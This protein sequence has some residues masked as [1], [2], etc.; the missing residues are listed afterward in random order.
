LALR[1][2]AGTRLVGNDTRCGLQ[3]RVNDP[4]GFFHVILP[5]KKG[6]VSRHRVSEHPFVGLHLFGTRAVS[7][8]YFQG[9]VP[10]FIVRGYVVHA[11]GKRD[12]RTDSQPAMIRLQIKALIHGWWLTQSDHDLRAGHGQ[13]LPGPEVEG[14]AAPAPGIDLQLERRKGL[15]PGVG[16]NA[17]LVAIATELPTD[18]V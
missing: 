11:D 1:W 8:R 9:I 18:K 4:P 3:H 7:P 17:W 16:L 10:C 12:V 15:R 2:P 5:G 6:G 14:N 13:T